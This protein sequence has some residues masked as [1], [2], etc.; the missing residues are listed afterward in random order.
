MNLKKLSLFLLALLTKIRVRVMALLAGLSRIPKSILPKSISNAGA[1]KESTINDINNITRL[2]D[3]ELLAVLFDGNKVN[4][5]KVNR[6]HKMLHSLGGLRQL[7]A[8]DMADLRKNKAIN[9]NSRLRLSANKE[10]MHRHLKSALHK[11]PVL[12]DSKAVQRYVHFLL[13]DRKREVFLCIFLDVRHYVIIAQELFEGSLNG[14]CVY[15]REILRSCLEHHA[16]SVILVHNHPSG[17]ANPSSAD[18]RV[19]MR[20]KEAL[21]L[22]DI[23]LVDHLVVGESEVVSFSNRGLL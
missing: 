22:V 10:L 7:L 3:A 12:N 19:T 16:A 4:K 20:I 11:G 13:R 18:K 23:M 1:K 21:S 15:P 14:T 8:I 17:N 6:Y 2:S 9:M 5:A